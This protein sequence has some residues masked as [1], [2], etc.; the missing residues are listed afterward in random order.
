[1]DSCFQCRVRILRVGVLIRYNS[2]LKVLKTKEHVH[3]YKREISQ[4]QYQECLYQGSRQLMILFSDILVAA[5][6]YLE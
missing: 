4:Q 2:D 3:Y 5:G 1:M 6:V